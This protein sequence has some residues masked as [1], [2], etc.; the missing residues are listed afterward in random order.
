MSATKFILPETASFE[1]NLFHCEERANSCLENLPD[2]T[3]PLVS[4]I[5]KGNRNF[6]FKE[7]TS[8]TDNVEFVESMR[9]LVH[10]KITSTRT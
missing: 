8:K 1:A 6:T 9:K 4:N 3:S 10:M 7:V 2:F 5:E